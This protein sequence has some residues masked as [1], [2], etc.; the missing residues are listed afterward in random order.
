MKNITNTARLVLAEMLLKET[1]KDVAFYAR[2]VEA[3]PSE[4]N[5]SALDDAEAMVR[6]YGAEVAIYS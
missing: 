1:Q 5:R 4:A 3:D 6:F 2:R